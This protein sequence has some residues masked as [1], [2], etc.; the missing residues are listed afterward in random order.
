VEH[1]EFIKFMA[2]LIVMIILYLIQRIAHIDH[3]C[4]SRTKL[5]YLCPIRPKPCIQGLHGPP[6][7]FPVDLCTWSAMMD[8]TDFLTRGDM[9]F[10]PDIEFG[11]QVFDIHSRTT[12]M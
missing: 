9:I 5:P 8:E 10:W 1:F 7:F 3:G 12:S 2:S 4:L 11:N 6:R